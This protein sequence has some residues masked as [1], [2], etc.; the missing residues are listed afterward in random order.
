[1]TR[2]TGKTRWTFMLTADL[3]ISRRRGKRIE[4][5]YIA[6]TDKNYLQ[7]ASDLIAIVAQNVNAR[8]GE[9]DEALQD[10]VG[11]GTDY[12]ILRGLIKLLLDRCVFETSLAIEPTE[13]RQK[14]FTSARASHPVT[15]TQSREQI[16]NEVAAQLQIAADELIEHLYADLPANQRLMDFDEPAAEELID[17]YNLAQAQALLYRS[18][19]MRLWIEPQDAAGYRQLFE[20]IK[21][22][23]L[24][25]SISGTAA[26]GYAVKLTGPVAMFHRSQK[27]G[28]QMAVFLPSLLLCTGWQMRA[29]IESKFGGTLFYELAGDDTRLSSNRLQV[30][31][32]ENQIAEK[33]KA[34]WAKA[35]S[36]WQLAQCREVIDLGE[37]AFVPDFVL[38]S[39]DGRKIY[40]EV[41]GFWTPRY[42]KERLEEFE[43]GRFTNFI[44]IISEDLRGSRDA[45]TNL[46]ANV[47]MCKTSVSAKDVLGVL[48]SF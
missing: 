5:H 16:I 18:V 2:Q 36:D 21:A 29:E 28:I 22:H 6:P 40:L 3:A 1:M 33:L 20:A 39:G 44:L 10:Y 42:L 32:F 27:Y 35:A 4:P 25:H 13:I 11:T 41:L 30:P 8:R 45:P 17:A 23:R 47:L 37:S 48:Q 38:T 46:P 26:R 12:K 43:R 19:E 24:I 14:L 9:L 31:M 7:I 15:S 34:S